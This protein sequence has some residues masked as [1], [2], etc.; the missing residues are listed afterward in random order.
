MSDTYSRIAFFYYDHC[1]DE[2]AIKQLAKAEE[3]NPDS[4]EIYYVLARIHEDDGKLA[5]ARMEY[6]RALELDP[7]HTAARSRLLALIDHTR[8]R[9]I[10]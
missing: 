9:V 2:E 6:E 8:G 3:L 7:N 4:A 1:F 10:Q 5:L